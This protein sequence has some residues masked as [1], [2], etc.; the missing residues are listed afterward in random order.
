MFNKTHNRVTVDNSI[1]FPEEVKIIHQNAPTSKQISLL[2]EMEK[3]LLQDIVGNVKVHDN[4]F[5]FNC[6]LKQKPFDEYELIAV[7]TMNGKECV[8]K[9]DFDVFSK[10][11]K[12]EHIKKFLQKI[13]DKIEY[14]FLLSNSGEVEKVFKNLIMN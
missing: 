5:K 9:Y 10:Q 6:F 1:D 11:S 8:V 7:F 12:Q 2:R 4:K 3:E 13:S 14:E